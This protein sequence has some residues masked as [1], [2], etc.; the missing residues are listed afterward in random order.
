MS[1]SNLGQRRR[2]ELDSSTRGGLEQKLVSPVNRNDYTA[3]AAVPVGYFESVQAIERTGI[4]HHNSDCV[5]LY[6]M[7]LGWQR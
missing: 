5:W 1:R 7:R 6:G 2:D 3:N 4:P